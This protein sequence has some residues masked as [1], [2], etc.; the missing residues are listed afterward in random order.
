MDA[1]HFVER[2]FYV[3]EELKSLPSA[4]KVV[5]LLKRTQEMLTASNL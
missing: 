1:K 2:D 4:A 3:D 5:D